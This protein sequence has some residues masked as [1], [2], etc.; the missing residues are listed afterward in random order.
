MAGTLDT[1]VVGR[2][3]QNGDWSPALD[4]FYEWDPD[5]IEAVRPDEHQSVDHRHLRLSG[6]SSSASR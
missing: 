5:W 6:S 3:R 2:L 1:P 4:E